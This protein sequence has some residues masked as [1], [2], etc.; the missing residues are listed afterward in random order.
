MSHSDVTSSLYRHLY[1]AC[2]LLTLY[3]LIILFFLNV[4]MCYQQEHVRLE[5]LMMTLFVTLNV[6]MDVQHSVRKFFHDHE[7]Q[8][9]QASQS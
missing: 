3:I 1:Q 9:D 8:S 2:T 6:D 4:M 5:L 7:Q